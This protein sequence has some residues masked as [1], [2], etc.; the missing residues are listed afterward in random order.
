MD[1]GTD[2]T[3]TGGRLID[4]QIYL[5]TL[6]YTDMDSGTDSTTASGRLI[7][8]ESISPKLMQMWIRAPSRRPQGR[9]PPR[10]PNLSPL[11]GSGTESTTAGAAASSTPS[12]YRPRSTSHSST[13]QAAGVK[14]R[15]NFFFSTFFFEDREKKKFC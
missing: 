11:I 6:S 5:T 10:R 8:A 2:S 1:S 14:D 9:P 7:D 4:A 12:T 15:I 3:A 13:P